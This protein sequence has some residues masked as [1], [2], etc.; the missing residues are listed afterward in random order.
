MSEKKLI[1]LGAECVCGDLILDQ[2]TVG[3]YRD[4]SF[5]M[6]DDGRKLLSRMEADEAVIVSVSEPAVEPEPAPA[7]APRRQRKAAQDADRPAVNADLDG[8]EA[9]PE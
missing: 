5:R 2:K 6:T 4:G 7:P 3:E 9:T 1:D 8:L